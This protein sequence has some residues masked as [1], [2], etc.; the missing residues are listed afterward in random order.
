MAGI[1]PVLPVHYCSA[2]LKKA[3]IVKI[4]SWSQYCENK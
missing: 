1:S 4:S 2:N 3:G